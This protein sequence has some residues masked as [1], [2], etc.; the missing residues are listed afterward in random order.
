MLFG[1]QGKWDK[2]GEQQAEYLYEVQLDWNGS[3]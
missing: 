2:I 1:M 3:L